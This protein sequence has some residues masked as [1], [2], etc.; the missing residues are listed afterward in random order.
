MD[1]LRILKTAA[2]LIIF[3]SC[4]ALTTISSVE[5]FNNLVNE[6]KPIILKFSAD[7]CPPCKISAKP[8]EKLSQEPEFNNIQFIE[9]DIQSPV[10]QTLSM[11]YNVLGVPTFIFIQAGKEIKRIVGLDNPAKFKEN[12][13]SKLKEIFAQAP[14]QDKKQDEE[15]IAIEVEEE[16]AAPDPTKELE[17]QRTPESA[18]ALRQLWHSIQAFF[19]FM[20]DKLKEVLR[21]I[22]NLIKRIFGK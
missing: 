15:I 8:F 14:Q 18:G 9:L 6:K 10:G 12:F 17:E 13:R 7:Y 4:S 11:Q 1:M 5:Q 21:Y 3:P 20:F 22:I 19:I 16:L 2:L